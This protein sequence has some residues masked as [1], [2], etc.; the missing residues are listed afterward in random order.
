[1]MP[2]ANL[3]SLAKTVLGRV[4][5]RI[6]AGS[7]FA[8]PLCRNG[9]RR[10]LP[11]GDPV[12]VNA[13][14]P[15]CR[16]AERHRFLWL[17]MERRQL[18]PRAGDSV[19]H[20]APEWVLHRKLRSLAGIDYVS[21]D[22]DPARA[23]LAMD[24]TATSFPDDHFNWIICVHVLEHIPED[25]KAMREMFRILK[26]GGVLL[27]QVPMRDQPATY[28]DA[29]VTTPEQR[30]E[31]F[32]QADHVRLY[33]LDI[34]K[35]LQGSGFTVEVLEPGLHCTAEEMRRFS[36]ED[37]T[38]KYSSLSRLYLCQKPSRPL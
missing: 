4:N 22:L 7:R 35:R 16:S 26:P 12:R 31:K 21:I 30:Y 20:V 34:Q 3:Q 28:E 29:A 11:F 18:M 36:L 33:G 17:M 5:R 13:M 19:L 38:A 25:E 9:F 14:C 37:R 27:V 10:M 15:V 8:C 24:L 6:Y 2:E 32:G 23:M 1:M